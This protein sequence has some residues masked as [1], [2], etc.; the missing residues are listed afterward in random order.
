VTS[1]ELSPLI[2]NSE[3]RRD[4]IIRVKQQTEEGKKEI[5]ALAVELSTWLKNGGTR[6]LQNWYEKRDI[7]GYNPR[8]Y[9]PK[10]S[11][12]YAA[13]E[14]SKS[15]NQMSCDE[16]MDFIS[17]CGYPCFISK[18]M[19]AAIVD[20]A[21]AADVSQIK[22]LL[23][24]HPD[25]GGEFIIKDSESK[26]VVRALFFGEKTKFGNPQSN[27]L[28]ECLRDTQKKLGEYLGI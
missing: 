3:N 28:S 20:S 12:F 7:S 18:E 8:I 24:R 14:A 6:I 26:K 11:G 5:C 2:I 10:F 21:S 23:L 13:V 22:R 19:I 9:A 16:V 15:N 17:F 25:C 27:N 4:V 1:N